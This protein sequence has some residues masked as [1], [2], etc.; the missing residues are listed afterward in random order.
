MALDGWSCHHIG[1]LRILWTLQ[2]R[3]LLQ[4]SIFRLVNV[5]LP[6]YGFG[7]KQNPIN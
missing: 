7:A 5:A 2:R 1:M 4:V 6:D 3:I